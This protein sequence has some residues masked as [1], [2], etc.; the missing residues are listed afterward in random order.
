MLQTLWTGRK[1]K[2]RL[3]GR[4]FDVARP[5]DQLIICQRINIGALWQILQRFFAGRHDIGSL[6]P[7]H[8]LHGARAKFGQF[9]IGARGG[10][11]AQAIQIDKIIRLHRGKIAM[12]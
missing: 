1:A 12:Q 2:F 5:S 6:H 10:H 3:T 11:N 4:F 9:I 7:R 8:I